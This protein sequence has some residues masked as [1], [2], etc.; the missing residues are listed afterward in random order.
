MRCTNVAA[1]TGCSSW[2]ARA[3]LAVVIAVGAGCAVSDIPSTPAATAAVA[4]A[5]VVECNEA[6]LG[7]ACDSDDSACT[8]EECQRV[9]PG[10]GCVLVELAADGTACGSDGDPCSLDTCAAGVCGHTP[11]EVGALCYDG[12]WCTVGERCD[13]DGVCGG[14]DVL[15]DDGDPCTADLC[16]VVEGCVFVPIDGCGRP[17]GSGDPP[18]GGAAVAPPAAGVDAGVATLLLGVVAINLAA[19]LPVVPAQLGVQ[20]SAIVVALAAGGVATAPALACALAYRAAHAIP[21][22]TVGL[23]ALAS[24][25]L[26]R[27]GAAA[28]TAARA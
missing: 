27:A 26:G 9:G 5:L 8:V 1:A 7:Q 10:V 12:A 16:D 3:A 25:G 19:A 15:C 6:T 24:L 2:V 11:L 4:Q 28:A 18:G 14:G 13:A 23:P 22:V 21:L 20:E 17:G